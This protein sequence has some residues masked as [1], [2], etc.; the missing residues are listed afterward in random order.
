MKILQWNEKGEIYSVAEALLEE[1]TTPELATRDA[2][3]YN[4]TI[5]GRKMPTRTVDGV[6][7][8]TEWYRMGGNGT[9]YTYHILRYVVRD[10]YLYRLDGESWRFVGPFADS[11]D[12]QNGMELEFEFWPGARFGCVAVA[13]G[14]KLEAEHVLDQPWRMRFTTARHVILQPCIDVQCIDDEKTMV[15]LKCIARLPEWPCS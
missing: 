8:G 9:A 12:A 5:D 7:Y 1:I 4:K 6:C 15:T 2:W 11:G 3:G 10:V 14:D 13:H